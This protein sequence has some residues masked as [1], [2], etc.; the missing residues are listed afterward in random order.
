M[1][2]LA[3]SSSRSGPFEHCTD[4]LLS[5]ATT[6]EGLIGHNEDADPLTSQYAYMVRMCLCWCV[7]G[8]IGA[9]ECHVCGEWRGC[10]EDICI[11]LSRNSARWWFYYYYYYLLLQDCWIHAGEAWGF[12]S[13]QLVF[14]QNA[15][16]PQQVSV[17]GLSNLFDL[18][19]LFYFF[20]SFPFFFSS[21]ECLALL[22]ARFTTAPHCNVC[23]SFIS[24]TQTMHLVYRWTLAPMQRQLLNCTTSRSLRVL[25]VSYQSVETTHTSIFISTWLCHS[26]QILRHHIGKSSVFSF[27]LSFFF[28]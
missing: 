12:S 5:N 25:V 1:S 6:M 10:S 9:V 28:F 18:T 21:H 7:L 24:L 22:L 16:F 3:P 19:I 2:A 8:L 4:I 17:K 15:V 11:L 23:C 20:A 27:F 26:I 14:S 13:R